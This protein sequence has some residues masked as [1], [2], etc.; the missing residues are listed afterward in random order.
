MKQD[1]NYFNCVVG[2][3]L[4]PSNLLSFHFA[5]ATDLTDWDRILGLLIVLPVALLLV[6][7]VCCGIPLGIWCYG[8]RGRRQRAAQRFQRLTA[9][10]AVAEDEQV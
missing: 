5:T 10:T 4:P 9:V 1:N 3:K 8:V 6:A 2:T 7:V